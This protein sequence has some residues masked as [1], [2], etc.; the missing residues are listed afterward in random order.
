[1]GLYEFEFFVIAFHQCLEEIQQQYNAL[2]AEGILP[3]SV[4]LA[5]SPKLKPSKGSDRGVETSTTGVPVEGG[6]GIG[7][8]PD[9]DLELDGEG[10]GDVG[11]GDAPR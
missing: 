2:M 7:G 5:T 9:A 11:G 8:E 4:P 1:M 6:E 10:E 3:A